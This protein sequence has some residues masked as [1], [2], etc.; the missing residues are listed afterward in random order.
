MSDEAA[1]SVDATELAAAEHE[2]A[3][4]AEA[5]GAVASGRLEVELAFRLV[6]TVPVPDPE[7]PSAFTLVPLSRTF[8][9]LWRN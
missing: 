7:L 2:I 9:S 1:C 5:D 6:N 8:A 3:A 4:A